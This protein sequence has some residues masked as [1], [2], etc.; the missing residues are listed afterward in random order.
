MKIGTPGP[1]FHYNFGDHSVNLGTPSITLFTIDTWRISGYHEFLDVNIA[2][3]AR[4][5]QW[6]ARNSMIKAVGRW[7]VTTAWRSFG[8][9][10]QRF[11]RTCTIE[12]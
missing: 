7:P 9:G 8:K 11:A 1:H 12:N 5:S 2:H 4:G 3:N 6:L 10:C